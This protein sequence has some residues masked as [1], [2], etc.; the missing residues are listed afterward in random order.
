MKSVPAVILI[1]LFVFELRIGAQSQVGK[2]LDRWESEINEI[3]KLKTVTAA[4]PGHEYNDSISRLQGTKNIL[5]SSEDRNLHLGEIVTR[6]SKSFYSEDYQRS[7]AEKYYIYLFC[8]LGGLSSDNFFRLVRS[9]PVEQR[10]LV[11]ELSKGLNIHGKE[12]F[13]WKEKWWL[14]GYRRRIEP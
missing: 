1:Y 10:E 4:T 9:I 13:L 14:S 11:I 8:E 6:L 2:D 7:V 12:L 5:S 3:Y